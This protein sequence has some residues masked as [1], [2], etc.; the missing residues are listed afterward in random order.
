MLSAKTVMGVEGEE[1]LEEEGVWEREGRE[2]T[3][4]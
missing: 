4:L 2:T 3:V 1:G